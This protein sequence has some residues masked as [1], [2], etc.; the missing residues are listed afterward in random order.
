VRTTYP[1][2]NWRAALRQEGAQRLIFRPGIVLY[3]R[4]PTSSDTGKQRLVPRAAQKTQT[5]RSLRFSAV[6]ALVPS[7]GIITLQ[8]ELRSDAGA[9]STPHPVRARALRG[10]RPTHR[11]VDTGYRGGPRKARSRTPNLDIA[12]AVQNRMEAHLPSFDQ[13]RNNAAEC[14]RLAEAARTSAHKSFFIEMADRW[15]TLAER[16][17]KDAR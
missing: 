8:K 1:H 16:A 17:Q 10:V 5:Y 12:K 13:L 11:K 7:A 3:V 14:I 2:A 9:V 15:L 6:A 4:D